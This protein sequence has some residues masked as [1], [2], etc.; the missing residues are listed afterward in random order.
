LPSV[1]NGRKLI[2]LRD[3]GLC[4]TKL[5][6][7]EH[8]ADEWQVAIE[9]LMRIADLSDRPT[10]TSEAGLVAAPPISSRSLKAIMT[11]KLAKKGRGS[12]NRFRPVLARLS[13]HLPRGVPRQARCFA[14]LQYQLGFRPARNVPRLRENCSL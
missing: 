9:S 11:D 7:A 8:D 5:P 4:I 2:T 12:E 13:T 1:Q 14:A 10:C 3:A 6:K